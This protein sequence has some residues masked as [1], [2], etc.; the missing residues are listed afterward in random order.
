[1]YPQIEEQITNISAISYKQ[2]SA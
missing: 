1:V 2:P